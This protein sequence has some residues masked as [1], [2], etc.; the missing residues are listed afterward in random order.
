[1]LSVGK[2]D[3]LSIHVSPWLFSDALVSTVKCGVHEFAL[4]VKPG[5]TEVEVAV[6]H[7]T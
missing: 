7:R 3:S 5:R 6:G 1:M 4:G 2:N